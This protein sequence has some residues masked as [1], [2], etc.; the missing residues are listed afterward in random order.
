MGL[1][2]RTI[3]KIRWVDANA[4]L[5]IGMKSYRGKWYKDFA[6]HV[7]SLGVGLNGDQLS[8]EMEDMISILQLAVAATTVRERGY[9]H[10]K[11]WDFFIDLICLSIASKKLS[12]LN[13]VA[14]DI[15]AEPDPKV[16]LQKW[17]LAALPIVTQTGRN[18][19]L[20]ELL[21]QWASLL[22]V[23]SKVQTCEACFDP[24]GADAVRAAIR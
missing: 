5:H 4:A 21:A 12:E 1:F 19:K 13:R 3:P 10:L 8:P 11:D 23:K 16:S 18:Q 15:L 14:L 2:S 22:V 20:A 24:K 7:L 9:V 17:A 6:D